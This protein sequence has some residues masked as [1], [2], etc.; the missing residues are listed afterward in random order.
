M[1]EVRCI[2][3]LWVALAKKLLLNH[4]NRFWLFQHM[5]APEPTMASVLLFRYLTQL[6]DNANLGQKQNREGG[7]ET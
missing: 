2:N 4:D 1:G 5:N 6:Y 3:F 7:R